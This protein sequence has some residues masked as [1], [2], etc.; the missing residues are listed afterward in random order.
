VSRYAPPV[1]ENDDDAAERALGVGIARARAM[2]LVELAL[3]GTVFIY[4]GAELGLP[5]VDLPDEALVDPVWE[6]SGHT[7][8]GR[9]GCRV[10]LPWQGDEPPYGFSSNPNTWLPMPND[11]DR[12]TVETQLEDLEST[13]SLYRQA[14]ELRYARPEF[15]G[16][17]VDWYG[18]PDDC[19]AFRRPGGLICALNA[20]G[21]PIALPHGEILLASLPL[22]DG[23]LAP[24]SA[25]WLI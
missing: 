5:N 1:E 24:N 16:D 13:L 3:P 22:V 8:R 6:R 12:F 2:A 23:L 25:A 17:V 7:V 10:P 14:I 18:A 11:W 9:D 21:A 19:L 4:N 15:S 20:S